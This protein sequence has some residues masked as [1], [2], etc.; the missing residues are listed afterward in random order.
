MLYKK[1]LLE[2]II[3]ITSVK[4]QSKLAEFLDISTNLVSEWKRGRSTPSLEKLSVI[5]SKTGCSW[6]ELLTGRKVAGDNDQIELLEAKNEIIAGLKRE[7]ESKDE[8]KSGLER[9]LKLLREK[10]AILE[11]AGA[12]STVY[13]QSIKHS[14]SAG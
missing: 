11:S 7:L 12:S 1:D 6:D 5:V 9:E 10:I 4:N 8:M 2:N 14:E 3:S 13:E